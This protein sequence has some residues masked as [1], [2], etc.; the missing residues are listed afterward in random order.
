MD[1]L[2]IVNQIETEQKTSVFIRWS[3]GRSFVPPIDGIKKE[4]WNVTIANDPDVYFV[5]MDTK[6]K[7]RATQAKKIKIESIEMGVQLCKALSAHFG[8]ELEQIEVGPGVVSNKELYLAI[9][10]HFDFN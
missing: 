10:I 6:Y 8:E 3:K 4:F 5:E 1:I 9:H 7:G 2:D